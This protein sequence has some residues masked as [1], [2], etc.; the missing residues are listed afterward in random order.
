MNEPKIIQLPGEMF[1]PF[2]ETMISSIA[3]TADARKPGF[4]KGTII[5]CWKCANPSRVGDGFLVRMK[6]SEFNGLDDATKVAVETAVRGV[7]MMI[8]QRKGRN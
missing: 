7:K 8:A 5:V 4:Q 3:Q 6:E 2:C 1:C